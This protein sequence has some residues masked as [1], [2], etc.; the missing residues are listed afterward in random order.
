MRGAQTLR[1]EA[2]AVNAVEEGG[3]DIGEAHKDTRQRLY[4]S[5]Q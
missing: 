3:D 5:T 4:L 1:L 2:G